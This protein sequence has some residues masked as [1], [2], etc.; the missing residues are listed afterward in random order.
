[1]TKDGLVK[2]EN[3]NDQLFLK[4]WSSLQTA[5]YMIFNSL[6]ASLT[7]WSNSQTLRQQQLKGLKIVAE[8]CS[9]RHSST[10]NLFVVTFFKK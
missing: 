2:F 4:F 9:W 1:M 10:E 6:S 5:A 8:C 7:E 3:I